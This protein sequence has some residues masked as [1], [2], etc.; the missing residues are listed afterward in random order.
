MYFSDLLRRLP[1]F[2]PVFEEPAPRRFAQLHGASKSAARRAGEALGTNPHP[3][4]PSA[5]PGAFDALEQGFQPPLA[6][7]E[8]AFKKT[9][10]ENGERVSKLRESAWRL[11]DVISVSRKKCVKWRELE[12]PLRDTVARWRECVNAQ[13]SELGAI[14][15]RAYINSKFGFFFEFWHRSNLTRTFL[16][17]AGFCPIKFFSCLVRRN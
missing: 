13:L 7:F 5:L 15:R 3:Q 17:F 12:R 16:R 8:A 4:E 14:T 2:F 10:V 6:V 11:C 1:V 9:M